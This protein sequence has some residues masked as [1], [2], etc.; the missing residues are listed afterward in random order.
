MRGVGRT[1][2]LAGSAVGRVGV[3]GVLMD[4]FVK[5]SRA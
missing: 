5:T 1:S 4:L 2:A 3:G